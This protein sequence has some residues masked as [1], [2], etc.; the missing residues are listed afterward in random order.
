MDLPFL[1]PEIAKY[2]RKK[3]PPVEYQENQ[4]QSPEEFLA[5]AAFRAGQRNVLDRLDKIIKD[6]DKHGR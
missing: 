2:L 6:Q 1:D 4:K 3:L 5:E